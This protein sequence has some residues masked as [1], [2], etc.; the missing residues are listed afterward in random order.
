MSEVYNVGG[1][2][3]RRFEVQKNDL[4]EVYNVGEWS[5]G[6]LKCRRMVCL[7]V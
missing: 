7:E 1:L 4:S 3:C 5:V 6:D 2:K